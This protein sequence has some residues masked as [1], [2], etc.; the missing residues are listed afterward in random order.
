[1]CRFESDS[2]AIFGPSP[3]GVTVRRTKYIQLLLA[4]HARVPFTSRLFFKFQ[5][6]LT[7]DILSI[8]KAFPSTPFLFLYR[9]AVENMVSNFR[10]GIPSGPCLRSKLH[11]PFE[12][13]AILSTA[14]TSPPEVYCA[15]WI[16]HLR[17]FALKA[18]DAAQPGTG[19]VLNYST[20]PASFID[21]IEQ[22]Y[23]VPVSPY[24]L[25]RV[26][27]IATQYSKSR[28]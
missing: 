5:S 10:N 11:P 27:H 18:M 4:A 28:G 14:A 25:D 9:N 23:H 3:S 24:E 2:R 13:T 15:V 6:A 21:V 22:H 17:Q 20:L 19:A 26:L 7:R 16:A 1:M 8:Q 12:V